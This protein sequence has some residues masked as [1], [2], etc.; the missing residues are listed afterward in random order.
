MALR[1]FYVLLLGFVA[2]YPNRAA[3]SQSHSDLWDISNG[4]TITAT[5]GIRGALGASDM[6][7]A[8]SSIEPGDT[9][10]ADG[11]PNGFV[12]FIEW[13]TPSPV[14]LGSFNLFAVGD[15]A[16]YLNERETAQFVLKAKLNAADP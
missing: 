3:V 2:M 7:G 15:G 4:I 11:Q 14:R 8:T 6:F 12:H 9:I 5:S 10:F 16:V 1:F 13:K